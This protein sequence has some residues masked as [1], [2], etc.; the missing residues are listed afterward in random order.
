MLRRAVTACAGLGCVALLAASISAT[1]ALADTAGDADAA[2]TLF[3]FNGEAPAP[4]P[5]DDDIGQSIGALFIDGVAPEQ[6]D[7]NHPAYATAFLV[8][9]CHVIARQRSLFPLAE[10]TKNEQGFG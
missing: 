1:V 2:P 6:Y 5:P 8:S 4:L 9:D 7:R 3:A 10:M